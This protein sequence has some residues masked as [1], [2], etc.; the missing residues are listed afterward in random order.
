MATS[1]LLHIQN[2]ILASKTRKF[3]LFVYLFAIGNQ[4]GWS[5]KINTSIYL[6][7]SV[8]YQLGEL[9]IIV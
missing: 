2:T 5:D 9:Q 3:L 6:V 8:I 4:Q 1:L 7:P